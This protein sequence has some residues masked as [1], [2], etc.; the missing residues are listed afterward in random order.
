M[1]Y[2]SKKGIEDVSFQVKEGEVFGYLGP[3]GAGKTTTIRCMLGFMKAVTGEV[4]INGLNSWSDAAKIQSS[5]GYIPGEMALFDEMTGIEFLNFQLQMR[6]VKDKSRLNELLVRFDLDPKGKIRK[7]SKGMKQKVG[8]IAAFMHDPQIYI[9]D[10]PSSGLDPLMQQVFVDLIKEER[11]R[12]KTIL[13]S[14]HSFEEVDKTCD[15]IAM[16]RDGKIVLVE[17]IE[18]VKQHRRKILTVT[19]DNALEISKMKKLGISVV[20]ENDHYAE[21]EVLGDFKP[22]FELLKQIDVLD[23]DVKTQRLEDIF[24]KF[25]GKEGDAK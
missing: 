1:L 25:Y 6:H 24:M 8:L 17:D 22:F 23:L 3:N 12:G 9:L 10:E 15:R 5:V 11:K 18:V 2:S 20:F 7:M 19:V 16:I 14:S 21:V 13:M 4:I